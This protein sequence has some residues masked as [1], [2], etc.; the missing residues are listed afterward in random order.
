ML[1]SQQIE[2]GCFDQD[3]EDPSLSDTTL[4]VSE[5]VHQP[6]IKRRKIGRP[7][8]PYSLCKRPINKEEKAEKLIIEL[9]GGKEEALNLL[10]KIQQRLSTNQ[11]ILDQLPKQLV[12][13]L[14]FIFQSFSPNDPRRSALASLLTHQVMTLSDSSKLTGVSKAALS[15]RNQ[16]SK[17]QLFDILFS[18]VV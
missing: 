12:T 16:L 9:A 15:R 11:T 17:K 14:Q 13:N 5:R 7:N 4:T 3:R 6:S 18:K 8:K 10:Q 1:S 2:L